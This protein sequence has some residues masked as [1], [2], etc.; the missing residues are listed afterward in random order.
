MSNAEKNP[1]S[2]GQLV[3]RC[4]GSR[5]CATLKQINTEIGGRPEYIDNVLKKLRED[6][7][8]ERLKFREGRYVRYK[9]TSTPVQP[10]IDKPT[11]PYA[12]YCSRRE[13]SGKP[14]KPKKVAASTSDNWPERRAQPGLQLQALNNLTPLERAWNSRPTP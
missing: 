4:L 13:A 2:V 6:G 7:V 10:D 8:V 5:Y 12:A 14:P 11:S 9:L 3:I 1:W